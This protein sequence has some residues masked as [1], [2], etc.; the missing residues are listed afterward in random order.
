MPLASGAVWLSVP[1]R[2]AVN[3]AAGNADPPRGGTVAVVAGGADAAE[4]VADAAELVADAAATSSEVG[5][6]ARRDQPG[7]SGPATRNAT[8]AAA[9]AMMP[10][11]P[12]ARRCGVVERAPA[13]RH[14]AAASTPA[15]QAR[16]RRSAQRILTSVPVPRPWTR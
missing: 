7:W 16:L 8:T 6:P 2:L 3:G 5:V 4:L 1:C 13:R 12:S 9:V 10:A 15:R 11:A 14:D